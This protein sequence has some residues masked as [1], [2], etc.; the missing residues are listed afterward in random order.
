LKKDQKI[1]EMLKMDNSILESSI[2]LLHQ[3]HENPFS[4]WDEIQKNIV[5][6]QRGIQMYYDDRWRLEQEKKKNES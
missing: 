4:A 6:A 1:A 5:L 3:V 2:K